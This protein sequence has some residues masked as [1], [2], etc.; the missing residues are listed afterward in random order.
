MSKK[1]ITLQFKIIQ[2]PFCKGYVIEQ[3]SEYKRFGCGH[4]FYDDGVCRYVFSDFTVCNRN[5]K[6]AEV[7]NEVKVVLGLKKSKKGPTLSLTK[8]TT[9]NMTRKKGAK[10]GC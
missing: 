8:I 4:I 9:K 3:G 7:A 5:S 2:C 10:N 6:V 1:S